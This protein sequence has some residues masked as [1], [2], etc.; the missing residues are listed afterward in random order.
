[1]KVLILTLSAGQ[2][3]NSTAKAVNNVF[4]ENGHDCKTI[5]IC[6]EVNKPLGFTVDKGYLFSVN[7]LTRLYSKTYTKLLEREAGKRDIT[8]KIAKY[9]SK[10]LR[11]RILDFNPDVIVCTHVF[12]G[13]VIKPYIT[14]KEI[15]AKT[16]GILTDYTLHPYWEE[17]TFLDHIVIPAKELSDECLRKGYRSE[18][19]APIGIPIQKKF[20]THLCKTEAREK[21]GLMT[22]KPV[23]T[24]MSGSMC[25]GGLTETVK[26]LDKLS[27]CFQLIA[28]CGSSKKELKKLTESNF[29]HKVM[30]LGFVDN[31]NIIMD[32]SDCIIT[33]P[34]GISTAEAI[35]RELPMIVSKAIPGHE[36]RNLRFLVNEGA[37]LE[38]T[39]TET[40]DQLIQRFLTDK[41]L[42][43][44]M[45]SAAKRLSRNDAANMLLQLALH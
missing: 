36:E 17:T 35:S 10:K 15:G 42:Q 18:Q 21:L 9:L 23:I 28:I 44:S 41:E 32:A 30:K 25:Y 5:D 40:A 26:A 2:G 31:V 16:I 24:V 27:E 4:T 38:V 43:K 37:A 45:L 34:G 33:K 14:N 12:C 39:K 13:M 1:M 22:D 8:L 20:S 19:L 7:H 11:T 29:R 3:H 6:Y